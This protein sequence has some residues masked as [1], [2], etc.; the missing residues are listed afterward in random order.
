MAERAGTAARAGAL[1]TQHIS[2]NRK[3]AGSRRT[4]RL[5]PERFDFEKVQALSLPARA[6]RREA[7][8]IFGK[9]AFFPKMI[10]NEIG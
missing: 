3:N 7:A 9:T 4:K 6:T 2:E 10:L 1:K 8:W 5:L